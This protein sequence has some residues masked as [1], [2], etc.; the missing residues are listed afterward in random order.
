MKICYLVVKNNQMLEVDQKKITATILAMV[1]LAIPKPNSI[2]TRATMPPIP[3][4]D[5]KALIQAIIQVKYPQLLNIYFT[6]IR[7]DYKLLKL[8]FI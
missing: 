8:D 2:V 7:K 1:S 4:V 6:K 3:N 5:I